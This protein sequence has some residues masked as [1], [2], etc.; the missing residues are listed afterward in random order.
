MHEGDLLGRDIVQ[1]FRNLALADGDVGQI[2]KTL[3][4]PAEQLLAVFGHGV[5]RLGRIVIEQ[6]VKI[7]VA[8]GMGRKI[9]RIANDPRRRALVTS[10]LDEIAF[11]AQAIAHTPQDDGN[12]PQHRLFDRGAGVVAK[13]RHQSVVFQKAQITMIRKEIVPGVGPGHRP[14]SIQGRLDA[15]IKHI[16]VLQPEKHCLQ[17]ILAHVGYAQNE[18]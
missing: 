9:D 2:G 13:C 10:T 4:H 1:D 8:I 16:G 5:M 6:I 3:R 12:P 11:Q 18:Y 15:F 17:V 14:N 7:V